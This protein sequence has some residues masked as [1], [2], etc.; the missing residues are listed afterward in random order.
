M[1]IFAVKHKLIETYFDDLVSSEFESVT[2]K[3]Q[4]YPYTYSVSS[5]VEVCLASSNMCLPRIRTNAFH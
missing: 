2:D 1:R 5:G 3:R 4:L